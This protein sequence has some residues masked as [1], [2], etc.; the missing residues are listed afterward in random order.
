[1]QI[2]AHTDRCGPRRAAQVGAPITRVT[3]HIKELLPPAVPQCT[4]RPITARSPRNL[5]SLIRRTCADQRK[6]GLCASRTVLLCALIFTAS[7]MSR[8]PLAQQQVHADTRQR[9]RLQR[10]ARHAD[11]I[12]VTEEKETS[13]V[14][15]SPTEQEHLSPPPGSS[16]TLEDILASTWRVIVT[17]P[18]TNFSFL[19]FKTMS[20]SDGRRR[21]LEAEHFVSHDAAGDA[22]PHPL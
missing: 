3:A 16:L 12:A 20:C 10:A 13:P 19:A 21:E 8:R 5:F 22:L 17:Q 18:F 6:R 9:H 14:S 11:I 4:G 15:V 1:M 2:K 7:T